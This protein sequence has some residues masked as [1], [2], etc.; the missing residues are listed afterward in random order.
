MAVNQEDQSLFIPVD[1]IEINSHGDLHG[2][3]YL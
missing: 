2:Q 3:I 1:L